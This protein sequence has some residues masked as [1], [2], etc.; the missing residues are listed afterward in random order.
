VAD[1][2]T[3]TLTI[4]AGSGITLTTNAGTDTLTIASTGGGGGSS[5]SVVRTQSG[6]SYT[7]AASDAGAYILTS[8]TTTV[9]ITVPPQSSVTWA[10]DTEIYFE[11]N[12]TGQITIAGGVGVTVN[13]SETLKSFARYSVLALKRVAENVWTLTGERAL[14]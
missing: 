4:V 10:A 7:L 2:H 13:T 8:G 5:Y 6:T 14:V 12:N 3:D 11:Q 9:T 1:T